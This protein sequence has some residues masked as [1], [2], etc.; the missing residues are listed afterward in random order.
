MDTYQAVYDAVRS[1]ISNGDIGLAVES[2]IRDSNLSHYAAMA[3]ESVRGALSEY[4]RPAVL[5]RPV[6]SLDGD[7]WCALYG[8][9][10]QCGVSG[11]GDSPEAAMRDFDR[12]W[13]KKLN[14]QASRA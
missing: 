3:F 1:R 10:L 8:S 6:L 13:S 7:Q 4:E 2:A 12:E 5:F 14:N 11:F 9:N